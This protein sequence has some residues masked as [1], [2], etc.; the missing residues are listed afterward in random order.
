[1]ENNSR[2]SKK[3][4][5]SS[6][7]TASL[8]TDNNNNN[9][10][11]NNIEEED[12]E[13]NSASSSLSFCDNDNVDDNESTT[14]M[15]DMSM[16]TDSDHDESVE[17]I[18]HDYITSNISNSNIIGNDDETELLLKGLDKL[19][20]L[21]GGATNT[22]TNTKHKDKDNHNK[23]RNKNK[24]RLE[25]LNSGGHWML[26]NLLSTF[27]AQRGPRQSQ[28]QRG[29]H[30]LVEHEHCDCDYHGHR[31]KDYRFNG[32]DNDNDND[33]HSCGMNTN[34]NILN[35]DGGDDF[36]FHRRHDERVVAI[37]IRSCQILRELLCA[38]PN[39]RYWEEAERAEATTGNYTHTHATAAAVA[40]SNRI[41][42]TVR[43]QIYCAGSLDAVVEALRQFPSN[44][45]V[46]MAG[47]QFL[48]CMVA[49][50]GDNDGDN[51]DSIDKMDDTGI[52]VGGMDCIETSIGVDADDNSSSSSSNSN[53]S[54]TLINDL[55]RSTDGL[56]IV[57]RL[58]VVFSGAG[59]A[60]SAAAYSSGAGSTGARGKNRNTPIG[61]SELWRLYFVVTNIVRGVVAVDV[62]VGEDATATDT[63]AVYRSSL[64]SLDMMVCDSNNTVH[65][66]RRLEIIRTLREIFLV[67]SASTSGSSN[68]DDDS[69]MAV[70]GDACRL[71]CNLGGNNPGGGSSINAGLGKHM[72]DYLTTIL[73]EE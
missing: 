11:N 36:V 59:R 47:C 1:V 2:P 33:N 63:A 34:T 27:T 38:D 64:T 44:F 42:A 69:V 8:A 30:E 16:N 41:S 57:L 10:Y 54:V 43:Y 45:G 37:V 68:D 15:M 9:N 3:Q 21:V 56:K 48:S 35:N 58:L 4:R 17:S 66:G 23:N 55:Y 39:H 51:N 32:N 24:H 50:V 71:D 20:V 14:M 6:P 70:D 18:L 26:T 52:G 60:G 61:D 5:R 62:G 65:R 19:L 29:V 46:Q 7:T 53:P 40:A 49:F 28:A 72:Y 25:T 73:A 67:G 13:S 31:H 22:N 12:T